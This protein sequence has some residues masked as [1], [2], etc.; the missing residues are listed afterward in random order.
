MSRQGLFIVLAIAILNGIFSPAMFIIVTLH[1]L[2]Y[3]SLLPQTLP[4]LLMTSS[5]LT[6]T[7]TVMVA[8]V[9]AALYEKLVSG[10]EASH[11][12][13][14]IWIAGAALLTLPALK[15]AVEAMS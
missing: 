12:S 15:N 6:A 9:P 13:N 5:L 7:L 2:W 8:G 3:P 10:G 11:A 1:P 14:I 4:F